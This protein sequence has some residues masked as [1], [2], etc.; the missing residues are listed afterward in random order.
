[1]LPEV[2]RAIDIWVDG[3]TDDVER[4]CRTLRRTAIRHA[5]GLDELDTDVIVRHFGVLASAE[6]DPRRPT[7]IARISAT[8]P[9]V[10]D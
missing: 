1:M 6:F 3:G 8:G 10:G 4:R 7:P 5:S 9:P 2:E